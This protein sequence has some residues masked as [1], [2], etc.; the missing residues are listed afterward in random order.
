MK[1]CERPSKSSSRPFPELDP[2]TSVSMTVFLCAMT[3]RFDSTQ[4]RPHA[5]V[6]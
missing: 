4:A 5:T 6:S 3:A 2:R 1:L